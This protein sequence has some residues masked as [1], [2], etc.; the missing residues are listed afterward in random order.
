VNSIR[1]LPLLVFAAFS[2]LVLKG[3]GLVTEGGYVLTG[4]STAAASVEQPDEGHVDENADVTEQENPTEDEADDTASEAEAKTHAPDQVNPA[5]VASEER[6]G[7]AET[8]SAAD[9]ATEGLFSLVGPMA[10]NS[11]QLD[12]VPFSLNKAGEKVPL[13]NEDGTPSTELAVLERLSE[14]RAELDAYEN[15]LKSREA[16]IAAA[17]KRLNERIEELK[18]LEAQIAVLVERKKAA[19]DE[20]F[21]GLVSMYENMKPKQAATIFNQLSNEVLFRVAVAMNPRKMSPIL[22]AMIPAR[23]QQLTA[24]M[25]AQQ[26]E[27]TVDTEER[28]L[29]QLPQIVGQ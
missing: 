14:R 18:S 1:L 29:S 19:D 5:Q 10:V 27:L 8:T 25:A 4:V 28:D 16:V 20:Q 24:M 3:I 22:A 2:L 13:A 12:A 26:A 6:T 9:R 7:L 17:E 11:T 15:E 23:A 21:K